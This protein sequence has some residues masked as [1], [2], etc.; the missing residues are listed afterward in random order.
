VLDG[1][2]LHS[3]IET[4]LKFVVDAQVGTVLAETG[5]LTDRAQFSTLLHHFEGL[6]FPKGAYALTDE[7]IQSIGKEDLERDIL[8]LCDK[9]YAAKEQQF[10][11][12]VMREVERVI[13]LRV[14][15]EYWMD[16]IDAMS[17]LRQGITLRAYG[18]A[19]PVVEYKREGYEM[20][21]AMINAIR[22][23][24]VR[25]LF[26]VHLR[27]NEEIRR[28]K[29]AKV[30]FEGGADNTV[31][32]QPVFKKAKVG[33]NDPCPCGSGKKYKNCCLDKDLNS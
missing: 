9:T 4:M 10:T 21:E 29:V 3:N 1:C 30:T 7:Q 24:T 13:T 23:E 17:D 8:A 18:Q 27:T 14:V 5:Y 19:D 32:R 33:R 16:H 31:K 15:D 28:E 12:P 6:Y 26:L 2:D 20:F 11:S 25:R 22:E